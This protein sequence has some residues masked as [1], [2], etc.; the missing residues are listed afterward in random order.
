MMINVKNVKNDNGFL[1]LTQENI[2]KLNIQIQISVKL[3]DF[4]LAGLIAEASKNQTHTNKR[5]IITT[6]ITTIIIITKI[7][8]PPF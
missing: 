8:I 1:N 2:H 3:G 4:Y 5:M 7:I 6:E